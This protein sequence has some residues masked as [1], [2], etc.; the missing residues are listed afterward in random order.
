MTAIDAT[1]RPAQKSSAD[2]PPP[3]KPLGGLLAAVHA[4]EQSIEKNSIRV[5]L[6]FGV[7]SIRLPQPDRLAWY[8]GITTLAVLGV[9]EWPVAVAVAVGHL[10]AE[11]HHHR[12]LHD[13]GE[14]LE[15]A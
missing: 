9:V 6:P 11:N 2:E 3:G 7:G 15:E 1:V 14:A 13:F 12:L 4:A 8:A 5:T 10:I